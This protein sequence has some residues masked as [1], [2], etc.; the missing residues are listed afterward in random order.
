M[1]KLAI[2]NSK[3]ISLSEKGW[4][5]IHK[6]IWAALYIIYYNDFSQN[7]TIYI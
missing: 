4:I 7:K 2:K 5:K 3:S 6:S 1:K